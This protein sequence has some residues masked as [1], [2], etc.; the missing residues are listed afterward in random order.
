MSVHEDT[1]Q[2]LQEALEYVKGDKSKGRLEEIII[3]DEV[4]EM[5][6]LIFQQIVDLS[7]EN[8]QKIIQYA[9]ELLKVSSG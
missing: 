9:N 3:P 6:Q 7:K 8:K 2:G 1:L 5:N 4:I